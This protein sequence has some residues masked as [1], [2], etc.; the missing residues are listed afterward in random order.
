MLLFGCGKFTIQT[1]DEGTAV[2]SPPPV[3]ATDYPVNPIYILAPTQSQT[4]D[5]YST[6]SSP[7]TH[8]S[9]S[10]Y[11]ARTEQMRLWMQQFGAYETDEA[12]EAQL[13]RWD[14]DP[15]RPMVALTFDDGPV[16]GITDRILDILECYDARATFFVKGIH[17]KKGADLLRRAVAQGC[18]IGNHSWDHR[19]MTGLDKESLRREIVD[20]NKAVFEVI[21]VQ[22][23]LLRPPGGSCDGYL[24]SAARRWD[25]AVIRWSQ[26]GNVHATDPAEI[27]ANVLCQEVNGRTLC[28]GDIVLLH[29]THDYMIEA[30]ELILPMLIEQGYQLVTVSE[31]LML[32][33]RG[34]IYGERYDHR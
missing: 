30:V 27:A 6:P 9:D 14:I 16:P 32:S 17:V 5:L 19:I 8:I 31:L 22:I 3:L 26:S 23:H 11:L 24:Y 10:W 34:I 18:E 28:D 1:V 4:P 2:A 20:V 7:H 29:D 12:I 21:G 33:D 15:D 13:S 25:M